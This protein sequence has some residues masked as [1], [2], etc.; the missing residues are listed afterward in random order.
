MAKRNPQDTTLRNNR[1]ANKKIDQLAA[2][3]KALEARVKK[4]EQR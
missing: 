1:A 3:V 4:L 2:K